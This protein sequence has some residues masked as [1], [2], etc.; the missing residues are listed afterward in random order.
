MIY[1]YGA[2]TIWFYK[3]SVECVCSF[4][5]F[6][7]RLYHLNHSLFLKNTLYNQNYRKLTK[8]QMKRF[9]LLASSFRIYDNIMIW[10]ALDK[11]YPNWKKFHFKCFLNNN[12]SSLEKLRRALI[13]D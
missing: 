6:N 10:K 7:M 9:Y 13:G 5:I 1:L 8:S 3:E 12:L 4:D 2:K 11:E